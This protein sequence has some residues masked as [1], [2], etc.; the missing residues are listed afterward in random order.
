MARD[1][2]V[3]A[4]LSF[5]AGLAEATSVALPKD[6]GALAQ[7]VDLVVLAAARTVQA[8]AGATTLAELRPTLVLKG[9]A[10]ETDSLFVEVPGIENGEVAL[11]VAG[12]PR[13]HPGETY[14]LFLRQLRPGFWQPATAALGVF[15][16]KGKELLEPVPE[17]LEPFVLRGDATTFRRRYQKETLLEELRKAIA[18]QAYNLD[19]AVAAET[20]S[21]AAPANCVRMTHNDGI[22]LRWFGFETGFSI[23]VAATTP[24]QVGLADG[25]AGAVSSGTSAWRN[26]SAAKL[27]VNYSGVQARNLDCN[28][29]NRAGEVWFNDPCNQ[30][31]DLN[32]CAGV[33]AFGGSY[34][35]LTTQ[36]YDGATWHP[37]YLSGTYGPFV[38]V[39]N[40]SECIGATNFSEMM[41]HELGHTLFFGHH[42]DPNAVMYAYCCRGGGAQIYSTDKVCASDQY[43]TFLDVP[44]AFWA[45]SFIEAVEDAG[46]AS[47]CGG[48][49]F[50]P[51]N[52]VTRAQMAVFLLKAKH[53]AGYT[54]PPCVG[55]FADVPCPGYWVANWIEALATEGIT[56]G[57]GGGNYCPEASVTR[58]QMAVFLLK[59]KYG[60]SFL[61]PP[62]TGV[63]AD[64]PCPGYWAANWIEALAAEGIT[65]GCGGGN[66][67]PTIPVKR[68]QMAVFLTKTFS[69]PAPTP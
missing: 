69:L 5:A 36:T 60:S 53:G 25:G 31:A 22:P 8:G 32:L 62:C 23:A 40:G 9:Q 37:G 41:T 68:S 42:T 54:P 29:G 46:V 10:Q 64:V 35:S 34:Y 12:F 20:P 55:V 44:Y 19:R 33:L 3:V 52:L 58:A 66:N 67:C 59:A 14:L 17:A 28:Q 16:L 24:G 2:L 27:N 21:P 38:V 30:I 48:G 61:P 39:N 4:F 7:T 11:A 50:C 65:S 51:E 57:C 43:H 47:G 56:S 6:L 1:C 63:F 26:Y 49:N 45:W 18:G 13:L 15:V